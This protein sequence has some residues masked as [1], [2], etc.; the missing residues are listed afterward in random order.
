MEGGSLYQWKHEMLGVVGTTDN[1][2][3]LWYLVDDIE[4]ERKLQ[5]I[6]KE[7]HRKNRNFIEEEDT[8]VFKLYE[9]F[10]HHSSLQIKDYKPICKLGNWKNNPN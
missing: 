10:D 5:S 2:L 8:R 9:Y 1:F 3:I 7:L 6:K 4:G